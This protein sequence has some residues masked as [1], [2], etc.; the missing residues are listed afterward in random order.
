MKQAMIF[1]A[2]LG[3]RLQYLTTNK[4]KALVEVRGKTLLQY[5]IEKLVS[6]GFTDIV[7]NVH[8]FSDLVIDFINKNTPKGV[9]IKISNE[10]NLLL[11]TGGGLKKA[12]QF[13]NQDAFLLYNVDILTNLNL[14][15]LYDEHLKNDALATLAVRHRDG[16]R[17]LLFNEQNELCGW[18]NIATGE[19][20]ASR[21]IEHTHRL[22]F[23]G[24]HVVSKQ[25]FDM[26]EEE[27]VF[28]IVQLYLRLATQNRICGFLHDN[29]EWIDAGKPEQ[30]HKAAT[31]D[32]FF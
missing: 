9:E 27:G 16:N 30:L 15:K 20:I 17:F 14:K 28:S 24:I 2:G 21:S 7:V 3:T 8:H 26:I 31:I 6:F 22:A 11:D 4:P 10:S 12:S 23:S 25:I 18:E 5:A 32:E 19:Q 29:T 13:L 1:A